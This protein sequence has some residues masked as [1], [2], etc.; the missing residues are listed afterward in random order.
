MDLWSSWAEQL[1]LLKPQKR[2]F[3][4]QGLRAMSLIQ[5]AL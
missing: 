2:H 3:F 1:M 5:P 4:L